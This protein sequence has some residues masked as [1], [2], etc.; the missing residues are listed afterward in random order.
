MFTD[1]TAKTFSHMKAL[2]I[3]NP[4]YSV[5]AQHPHLKVTEVGT[6]PGEHTETVTT[7]SGPD[8]ICLYLKVTA[9]NCLKASAAFP[10]PI[11][12]RWIPAEETMPKEGTRV[13]VP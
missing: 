13:A 11:F 6:H 2:I 3:S 8:F 1:T 9:D 12:V 4:Q 10:M 5:R 7:L